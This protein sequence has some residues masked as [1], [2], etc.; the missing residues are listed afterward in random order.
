[1]LW[2]L[3]S[4]MKKDRTRIS[5]GRLSD[6][7][8]L[9]KTPLANDHPD[10]KHFDHRNFQYIV[11]N[12]VDMFG[13]AQGTIRASV[14]ENDH[15][16][17]WLD[18][19]DNGLMEKE[20]LHL[21][22]TMNASIN[23]YRRDSFYGKY[24][25]YQQAMTYGYPVIFGIV[26]HEVAHMMN[27]YVMY[28]MDT[29]FIGKDQF[30]VETQKI[31]DR[32]DELCADY[33]S[34]V[35]LAKASPRLRLEPMKNFLSGTEA[36]EAHPDGFWRAFAVE[37]GYQWGCANNP[38]VT[39]GIISDKNK[40]RQL[41]ISFFQNY[42]QKVYMAVSPSVRRKYS[43]LSQYMMEECFTPIAKL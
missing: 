35:V 25:M 34:G 20:E 40:L 28:Q 37:M 36:D 13:L 3:M 17:G 18:Q 21:Q 22:F 6:P 30:L 33:L 23:T 2:G 15:W 38:A 31:N 16:V 42:Y 19:N 1:M 32:W 39:S 24:Y 27:R 14:V 43:D 9:E 5:F 7:G 11:D 8:I 29:K 10:L 26:A 41:L 12:I 4:Q